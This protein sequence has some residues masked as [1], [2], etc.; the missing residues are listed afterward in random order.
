MVVIQIW[1]TVDP[2]G[3]EGRHINRTTSFLKP[4][5]LIGTNFLSLEFYSRNTNS[6]Y[7]CQ[8]WFSGQVAGGLL[9]CRHKLILPAHQGPPESAHVT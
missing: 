4:A 9:V 3:K 2:E 5:G 7:P 1:I 6:F 8:G